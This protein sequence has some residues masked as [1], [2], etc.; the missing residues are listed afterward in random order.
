MEK[1]DAMSHD[2]RIEPRYYVAPAFLDGKHV[3]YWVK[4]RDDRTRFPTLQRYETLAE[5]EAEAERRL[6]NE[7]QP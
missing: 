5:A 2:T 4:D 6:T 7:V 3:G 1:G